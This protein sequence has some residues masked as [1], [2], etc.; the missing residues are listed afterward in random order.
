MGLFDWIVGK[1]NELGSAAQEAQME[2]ENWDAR[3]ICY[4]MSRTDNVLK[5]TG[6][7][8]ALKDKCKTM[9]DS[10]LTRLFDEMYSSRNAKACNAMMSEMRS[11]D[12]AYKDENGK[13][14]RNY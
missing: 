1:V 4:A 5:A 7:M 6:Y 2:A 12:L 13:I 8:R 9:N 10:E 11:R 3:K 14:I